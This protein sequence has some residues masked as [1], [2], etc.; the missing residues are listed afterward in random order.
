MPEICEVLEVAP[1]LRVSD[2]VLAAAWY[3]EKLG[4]SI[5]FFWPEPGGAQEPSYAIVRRGE[6]TLHLSGV[7]SD[8]VTP[9]LAYI[10]VSDVDLLAAELAERGAGLGS[11][12]RTHT[13]GMREIE[14]TDLDGNHL[15]FGQGAVDVEVEA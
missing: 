15:T 8:S 13:Y 9:A 6:A 3:S 7:G 11:G 12:P 5:D 10:F 2:P 1:I 4:F 14:L